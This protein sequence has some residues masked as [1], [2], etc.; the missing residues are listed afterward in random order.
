MSEAARTST[1]AVVEGGVR[2]WA[3]GDPAT[4]ENVRDAT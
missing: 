1:R 2:A 3:E 4:P